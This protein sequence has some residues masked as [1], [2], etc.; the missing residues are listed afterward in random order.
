M[1]VNTTPW[2]ELRLLILK[3]NPQSKCRQFKKVAY[4]QTNVQKLQKI[5]SQ[6]SMGIQEQI[7]YQLR[8]HLDL[9]IPQ[10]CLEGTIYQ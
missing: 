2:K 5:T 10:A 8:L 4:N 1:K 3:L 9:L 6:T 7:L